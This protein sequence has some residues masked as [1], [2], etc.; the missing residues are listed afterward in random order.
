MTLALT[1]ALNL[2]LSPCRPVTLSPCPTLPPSHPA[3][4]PPSSFTL[5]PRHPATPPP[6]HPVILTLTLTPRQAG[7]GETVGCYS[8]C[9]KLT[10]S[11]WG[12]GMG[13]TPESAEARPLVPS[14]WT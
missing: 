7:S 2:T 8:P 5:P 9:A 11:Q 3:S 10:Y 13:F 14:T 1:L 12:Q 4:L 6:R